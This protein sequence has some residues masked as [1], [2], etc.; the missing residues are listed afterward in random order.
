MASSDV[1]TITLWIVKKLT[2]Y[3]VLIYLVTKDT[4]NVHY[5]LEKLVIN[6]VGAMRVM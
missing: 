5:T 3:K 1:S 4:K 6:Y 2:N